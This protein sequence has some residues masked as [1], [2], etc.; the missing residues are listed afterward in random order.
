MGAHHD[1]LIEIE[2]QSSI[3][4]HCH[5]DD[6]DVHGVIFFSRSPEH[7]ARRGIIYTSVAMKHHPCTL[8]L[9][10]HRSHFLS[11]EIS[12]KTIHGRIST[13]YWHT[14]ENE[15]VVSPFLLG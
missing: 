11:N 1:I 3:L 9:C 6:L 4:F 10:V 13:I 14:N 7:A 5:D 15:C 2:T 8:I 12:C